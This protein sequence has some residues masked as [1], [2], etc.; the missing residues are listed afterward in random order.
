MRSI[1]WARTPIGPVERWSEA[2]QA[3]V[4]LLLHNQS[5]MLL[6]W[7]PAFVQLYNDA[8]RPVPGDKH[9]RAMGQPASECWAEIWHVIG[10]MIEAPFRGG[11]AS[12]S[13]DLLLAINR[14]GFVEETHFRVAYS[15][16]P[17]RAA[18]SGIGGVLA[19]VTETTEQ[20]YGERQLRTLRELGARGAA[21]ARS[22]AQAC[23]SA[24]ATLGGNRWDVPFSLFYLLDDDGRRA[25]LVAASGIDPARAGTCRWPIERVV[26]ER[27]IAVVEDLAPCGDAL[28]ASAWAERPRAAIALP[29]ASPDQAHAY[30]MLV[31]GVSPHR[32]LDVCYR[33]FFELAAA[34]VV[35]AI[36]NARAYEAERRRA[37]QLAELDRAKTAFFSNVSHEFRTPLTLMLGP[38]EDAL[39]AGGALAGDA[40]R[41]VHRN[42]L[43]LL[44]LV[45]ALLD[46][47]RM[48]AGRAQARFEP[49]DLA[50]VTRD[51]ASAFRSAIERAGLTFR[52]DCPPLGEPIWV[53][54][55]MWE[56]VVL[57]LLSNAL[58][59]TFEGAIEVALAPATDGVALTVRDTGTGIPAAELP[60]MFERF[61]RIEGQRGRTHEGS[62]I[63]LALVAEIVRMH[64]GT[65]AVDSA[66]GAGSTFTVTLRRGAAHLPAERT[67]ARPSPAPTALATGA[68]VEEAL[69][70]LP[71]AAQPTADAPRADAAAGARVLLV[72]DN[73]DMREYVGRLLAQRFCVEAVAHGGEALAAARRARPDLILSDVMMPVLDGFGLLREVRADP[74]LADVPVILLSARAGEESRVEGVQAG[75]DD[76]LVKPFSA[77][78]LLARVATH[79]QLA[80]LRG[81]AEGE[82]ARLYA[83]FEQAPVGIAVLRGPDFRYELVNPLFCAMRGRTREQFLGRRFRDVYPELAAAGTL[84][85]Y[86][87]ILASGEPFRAHDY[88]AIIDV[89][90]GVE[91][92][93][94][95]LAAEPLR[96]AGGRPDGV[97]VVVV[98]TTEEVRNRRKL[99][100]LR[101]ELEEAVAT[102]TAIFENAPVGLVLFDRELRYRQV[103]RALAAMNGLPVEAHLGKRLSELL[104]GLPREVEAQLRR[105]L[106][107]GE[108][109]AG[110]V[111][112]ETPALPGEERIWETSHFPVKRRDGEVI[113][114]GN[115]VIDV[116]ER[117]RTAEERRRLAAEVEDERQRLT[118]VLEQMPFGV[119]V[120]EVA[121][122]RRVITNPVAREIL[123]REPR[124]ADEVPLTRVARTGEPLRGVELALRGGDAEVVLRANAT[125][126]R[127]GDR[128]ELVIATF[129]D[130]TDEKRLQVERERAAR[131]AEQ[132][133]GILG[134]DL[135]NPLSS[136]AMSAALL[137]RKLKETP[138]ERI[139]ERIALSTARMGRMVDQLLDLTQGRLGGGIPIQRQPANLS[140]VV[141]MVVDELR[142]ANPTRAVSCEVPAAAPGGWDADRLAQVVSNLV[143]NA[144]GHGDPSRPVA[145]RL[146]YDGATAT[147]TVRNHGAAIPP[148]L[149]PVLF[150]PFRR[151]PRDSYGRTPAGLGLGLYITQQI[152][153]AHGG[154]IAVASNAAATTFTVTLPVVE[155]RAQAEAGR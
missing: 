154:A 14:K 90:N 6:W 60:R 71:D 51:L 46:F 124:A 4:A 140:E 134:H 61:H 102:F 83:V 138:Q 49:T 15:P 30:G 145:I 17:D 97:V 24:A 148:A 136:I 40:L 115:V 95:D 19:T 104:P 29:L 129:E 44:K 58:K 38:T 125:P 73:A 13:D 120:Y 8:Y 23:V 7:G 94:Y 69:R 153:R 147:L 114:V 27:T 34:Q 12:V 152:V 26:G 84:A 110:E 41:A 9:P 76:Y 89:G 28:P 96:D 39:A 18:P 128:I 56:K 52:I 59:F 43:R 77:R 155:A 57:N 81:A 78:E 132:F 92:R 62:G 10:P 1:D 21:E 113:G 50:T 93:F 85:Q 5:P 22:A 116:T 48:E 74:A 66:L 99:A 16:V 112:G 86:E 65:V 33:T 119:A 72:D 121:T 75:A 68:Y 137:A 122:G 105:V 135:R 142:A 82:R 141:T 106:D 139:V 150:E 47:S 45:N 103:N 2:L 126:V 35:T 98:D 11:P 20:M 100:K 117:R 143:G 79:L 42:E 131:F 70:W 87:H 107:G 133:I 91:E 80:Q 32:L 146:L 130:V 64:G 118:T 127:R 123:R 63:G 149:V 108:V 111:R 3:T 67:G 109:I 54:R 101:D 55:A 25:E 36:R 151:G 144:L 88:P 37:E 53:D 31:C